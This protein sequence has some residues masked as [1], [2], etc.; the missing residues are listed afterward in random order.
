MTSK[1]QLPEPFHQYWHM[2]KE[3]PKKNT[4]TSNKENLSDD[5]NLF[6]EAVKKRIQKDIPN[7]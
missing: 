3:L 5:W 1:D 2:S 6:L 4:Q 7:R